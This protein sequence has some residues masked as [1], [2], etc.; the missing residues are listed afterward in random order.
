L[1]ARDISRNLINGHV[2]FYFFKTGQNNLRSKK[3]KKYINFTITSEVRKRNKKVI[4]LE[5]K[6]RL[7]VLIFLDIL[8]QPDKH[9]VQPLELK[10]VS[11]NRGYFA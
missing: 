7:V 4:T 8:K 11:K 1:P 3:K 2:T 10:D 6:I 9:N 5:T